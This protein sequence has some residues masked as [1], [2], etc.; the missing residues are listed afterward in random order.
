LHVSNAPFEPVRYS[1]ALRLA[2]QNVDEQ[3]VIVHG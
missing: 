3:R 1:E 2:I